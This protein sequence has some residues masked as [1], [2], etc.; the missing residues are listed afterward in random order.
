M[1][2]VVNDSQLS[3]AA[4]AQAAASVGAPPPIAVPGHHLTMITSPR[5]VAAAVRAF[6]RSI[7]PA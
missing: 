6:I 3:T 7:S 2:F 5:Q 1:I 4:A